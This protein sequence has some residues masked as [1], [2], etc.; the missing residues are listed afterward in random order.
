MEGWK[1]CSKAREPKCY[2]SSSSA[3]VD[4]PEPAL[5]TSRFAGKNL[6]VNLK[7]FKYAI[8]SGKERNA[9]YSINK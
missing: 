8:N 1:P 6:P 4:H 3:N 5:N 7:T 2:N 9:S